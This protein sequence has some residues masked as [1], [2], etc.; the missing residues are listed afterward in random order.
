[1]FYLDRS[2]AVIYQNNGGFMTPKRRYNDVIIYS[3]FLKIL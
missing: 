2:S 3:Q 1:M